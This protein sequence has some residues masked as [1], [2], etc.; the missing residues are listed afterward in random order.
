VLLLILAAVFGAGEVW[1]RAVFRYAQETRR[2]NQLL[3]VRR[4]VMWAIALVIVGF[5]FATE[6][7]SLATFAGLLTAGIAVAMQG[8][9]VSIVG[10]FFLIGRYGLRVGDRVQIGTVTGEVIDLGLVRLHMM[11]L[12]PQYRPTGRV[13]AFANSV[14]FQA[15][16]GIFKQIP[17][18]NLA[19]REFTLAVPGDGDFATVKKRL[20]DAA[21]RVLDEY[22]DEL[23]RQTLALQQTTS[24][25]AAERPQCH[26]QL[27]FSSGSVE[28]IVRYPVPLQRA[29][30]VEE[31]M[32]RALLDATR[33]RGDTEHAIQGATSELVITST[34][35]VT[36]G[37]PRST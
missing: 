31:R 12:G 2:R 21:Q 20:L 36:P 3:L 25:G 7:S 14:V 8:P 10:Y 37:A 34:S 26:V 16:G 33:E 5:A 29:A 13:V 23:D 24:S 15:S 11:E 6:V 4:I 28:A 32:S 30:E 35:G 22:R 9:I 18:V 17:G 19:W 27:R 1:K